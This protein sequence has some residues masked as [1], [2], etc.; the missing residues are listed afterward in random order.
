M[1]TGLSFNTRITGKG[2]PSVQV[3][4]LREVVSTPGNCSKRSLGRRQLPVSQSPLCGATILVD[5]P[6][7]VMLTI[8]GTE[9]HHKPF[10]GEFKQTANRYLARCPSRHHRTVDI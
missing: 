4:T 1:L 9:C 6:R 8:I 7:I 2:R 3:L 5:R 10:A